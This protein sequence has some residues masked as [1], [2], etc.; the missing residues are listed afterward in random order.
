MEFVW[1]AQTSDGAARRT[2]RRKAAAT[3]TSEITVENADEHFCY[4]QDFEVLVCRK[5]TTAV[6]NLDKHLRTKHSVTVVERRA[7]VKKYS[8]LRIKKPEEVALPSVI[9]RPF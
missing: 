4:I 5:H 9:R 8:T 2:Q 1:K 6:Q 3:R 7:I